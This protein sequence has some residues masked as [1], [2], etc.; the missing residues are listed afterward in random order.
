MVSETAIDKQI[1]NYL[2][3]LTI[4]QKKVILNVVKTF[5]EKEEDAWYEEN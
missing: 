2:A 5:A 3:Q 1:N 4:R